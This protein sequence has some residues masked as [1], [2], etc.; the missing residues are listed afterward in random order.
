MLYTNFSSNN[1]PVSASKTGSILSELPSLPEYYTHSRATEIT[2]QLVI[3][4][5]LVDN[6]GLNGDR[7]VL[8]LSISSSRLLLALG[9]SRSSLLLLSRRRGLVVR[10]FVASI[11]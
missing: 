4:A 9:L 8:I 1:A 6:L 2:V 5:S 3:V 7:V 10:L 11:D